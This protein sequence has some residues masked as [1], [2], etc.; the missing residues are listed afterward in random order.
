MGQENYCFVLVRAKK[1]MDENEGLNQ[2]HGLSVHVT[3]GEL[4][5]KTCRVHALHF[6][7]HLLLVLSCHP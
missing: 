3:V 4:E 1:L 7:K 5:Q 6:S 2:A